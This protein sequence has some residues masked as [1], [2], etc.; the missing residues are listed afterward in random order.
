M[1]LCD[2]IAILYELSTNQNFALDHD[3]LELLR[4]FSE[5]L[6]GNS[7]SFNMYKEIKKND[8]PS[9]DDMVRN[10]VIKSTSDVYLSLYLDL[11]NLIVKSGIVPDTWLAVNW[12]I[13]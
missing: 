12:S 7:W 3:D 2:Y 9:G 6:L 11:F 4:M 13:L 5:S 8:K 10:E 1:L